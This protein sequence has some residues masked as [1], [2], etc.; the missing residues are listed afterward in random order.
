MSRMERLESEARVEA[1]VADEAVVMIDD[2]DTEAEETLCCGV[3]EKDEDDPDFG[4]LLG[5]GL[6]SVLIVVCGTAST[7]TSKLMYETRAHGIDKCARHDDDDADD[8]EKWHNCKF[9]KPWFQTLVMKLAMSLCFFIAKF[10]QWY[11]DRREKIAPVVESRRDPLAEA[12]LAEDGVTSP[13]R[14]RTP[15]N[16]AIRLI[17][18]PALTDLLQTV[19]A[20]AGLLWVTSSTYQMM[21]GSVIVFTCF[22]SIR[23]MGKKM[24]PVHWAAILVVI[25][26]I[27]LVGVAGLLGEDDSGGSAGTYALGIA[28]IIAGQ[29]VGAVQFVLEEYLMVSMD[30]TPTL[31]V[32]WEGIW[33]TLYFVVLAPLLTV[34]PDVGGAASTIWHEDFID[35]FIQLKN[36]TALIVLN[37]VSAVALLVYNLVGNMVT[38]QLSAIL[39]SILESCRTLGVWITGIVIWYAFRDH[40]SGEQWTVWSYLELLGFV[41]L[42]YGTIAYRELVPIPGFTPSAA[43]LE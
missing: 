28:L 19:L 5:P 29:V 18:Y 41:L 8:D 16:R 36:S 2:L 1:E 12:L 33:G 20:Q 39:R 38:K 23:F 43:A 10:T 14:R 42:V 7:I 22:L 21:R 31:L 25:L 27:V 37:V 26:A 24:A 34:S 17:A 32:G 9:T 13:T 4:C 35:T 30:V 15:S 3:L 11:R 6:L 40:D